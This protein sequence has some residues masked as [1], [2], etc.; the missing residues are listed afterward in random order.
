M[1]IS[2][3]QATYNDIVQGIYNDRMIQNTYNDMCQKHKTR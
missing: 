1:Y 2:R 3:I